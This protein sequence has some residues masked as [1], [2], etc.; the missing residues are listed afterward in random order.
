M[1][2]NYTKCDTKNTDDLKYFTDLCINETKCIPD[3]KPPIAK[4]VSTEICPTI[5]SL[6]QVDTPIGFS[7]AG[8]NLSG[9]K[10][11]LEIALN[12]MVKYIVD[13][14][15]EP[16]YI[17][18]FENTLKSVFIV[19][20][21]EIDG[22]P[23]CEL[24]RKNKYKVNIIIEKTDTTLIDCRCFSLWASILVCIDFV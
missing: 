18:H 11:V 22:V 15:D 7:N 17:A 13:S 9:A 4:L 6:K 24:I 23:L 3:N 20:P 14:C 8:Q 16:I 2:V 21:E 5:K 10:V 1:F 12:E 19:V